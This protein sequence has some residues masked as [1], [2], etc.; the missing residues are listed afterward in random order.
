SSSSLQVRLLHA[1][2]EQNGNQ[3][4]NGDF[5]GLNSKE[6]TANAEDTGLITGL[7]R[8]PWRRKSRPTPTFLPGKS[9]KNVLEK[10]SKI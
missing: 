7:G 5:P 4:R 6:S 3:K 8:F 2:I 1:S 10:A 9:P